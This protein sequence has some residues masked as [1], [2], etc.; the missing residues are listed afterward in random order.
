MSSD[1]VCRIILAAA[2]PLPSCEG[3][4]AA[5][6][7]LARALPLER[8]HRRPEGLGLRSLAP[9]RSPQHRRA[10]PGSAPPVVVASSR[11]TA[12]GNKSEKPLRKAEL[13]AKLRSCTRAGIERSM[14]MSSDSVWPIILAAASGRAVHAP[15]DVTAP[16]R[17]RIPDDSRTSNALSSIGFL[18][19]T[20]RRRLNLPTD[21]EPAYYRVHCLRP[22]RL[23]TA[24]N[25]ARAAS[26]HRQGRASFPPQRRTAD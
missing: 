23:P 2:L 26:P 9:L 12:P 5:L 22:C 10:T 19:R 8:F 15:T 6:G 16:Q 13:D 4:L 7:L 21:I 25:P 11:A 24:A 18:I 17:P 1:K 20:D 3:R 14:V